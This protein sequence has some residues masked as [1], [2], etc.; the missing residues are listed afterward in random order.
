MKQMCIPQVF[1]A[2]SQFILQKLSKTILLWTVQ[3]STNIT[4][5]G[6]LSS[7]FSWA[8][9]RVGSALCSLRPLWLEVLFS[10]YK[11]YMY[12]NSSHILRGLYSPYRRFVAQVTLLKD[13]TF[14]RAFLTYEN[15]VSE[16]AADCGGVV[17]ALVQC[18]CVIL[19]CALFLWNFRL[20][21]AGIFKQSM[22]ARNRAG[23]GLLYQPARLHKK[24]L[25]IWAL[26]IQ[27]FLRHI[28]LTMCAFP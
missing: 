27:A 6:R 17:M 15:V 14:C 22:G 3:Y 12:A 16:A 10:E 11:K 23:T 20:L 2:D 7:R 24:S 26:Y 19:Y 25:K 5:A 18:A 8:G 21:C 9:R 13:V 4:S 1:C 28:E